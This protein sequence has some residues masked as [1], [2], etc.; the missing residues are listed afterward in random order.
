M[1]DVR[2][3]TYEADGRVLVGT[4]A[5]PDG[6]GPHPGVLIGHEGPG[7]DKLQRGRAAQLAELGFVGFAIDYHG[8]EAP[9]TGRAS[10]MA[11]LDELFADPD[12]TRALGTAAYDVLL[13][14]APVDRDRIAAIGYC[15][16]ATVALEL[17]RTGADIK[18]VVG[19]HP[20]LTN[21]RP[22]DSANI[23]GKVL[24]CVGADDP[25]V[26]LEHRTTFEDEMRAAGVDWQLHVYGGV[27]HSFT[28]PLAGTAGVP[29]IAYDEVA[30]RRS[31]TAMLDLFAEVFWMSGFRSFR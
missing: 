29:G 7:L 21:V 11:R 10:M 6:P 16:G 13:A 26:P 4:L 25:I 22:A 27:Q 19:F 18:A 24:M 31:W 1:V 12:R 15:F 9:F 8:D 2:Q 20:G 30:A 23:T 28:H 5:V 17:A 14:E 3:I